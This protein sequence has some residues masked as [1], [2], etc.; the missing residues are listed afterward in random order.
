MKCIRE[1]LGP[2][3]VRLELELCHGWWHVCPEHR[4]AR[5]MP[6]LMVRL[7]QSRSSLPLPAREAL[8]IPSPASCSAPCH[9]G[10]QARVGQ[11]AVCLD[12]V[13][14]PS[15]GKF[16]RAVVGTDLIITISERAQAS[17]LL[18][19][20][21]PPRRVPRASVP[22]VTTSAAGGGAGGQRPEAPAQPRAAAPGP[23]RGERHLCSPRER[24]DLPFVIRIPQSLR[25]H[26]PP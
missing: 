17:A 21:K 19:E 7:G 12:L 20:R 24:E 2:V 1:L 4:G 16:P 8:P 11:V 13:F 14:S 9:A 22:A 23:P 10:S 3:L 26:F 18:L 15:T 5:L 25:G 6:S